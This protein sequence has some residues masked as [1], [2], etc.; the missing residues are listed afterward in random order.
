MK[1]VLACEGRLT[2]RILEAKF[3]FSHAYYKRFGSAMRAYELAGFLPPARTVKLID[4]QRKIKRLRNDLYIRLKQ[5][6]S[7]RVRFISLPGQQ[8]RQVV[9]IDG[10]LRIAIYLCRPT[11]ATSAGEPGW[12]VRVRP[13]EKELASL[14]CTMDQ[15]F[16]QL[17]NLY[18]FSS[19]ADTRKYRVIRE[20]QRWLSAGRK[21]GKLDDFCDIAKQVAAQPENSGLYIAVDDILISAST[22]M[23]ILGKKAIALGPVGS[24]IFNLLVLNAGQVVSRDRLRRAVPEKL[25]DPTNLNAHMHTLRVKLGVEAQNRI[26]RVPGIGYMYVSPDKNAGCCC[27]VRSQWSRQEGT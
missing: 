23:I 26:Q 12:I 25:L 3:T 10:R 21:L 7:D 22:W 8:F 15:T 27:G 20:N 4:T 14:I 6:F 11:N 17:L 18:V 13:A 24:A 2:K 16:S 5:L 19:L 1:R 9:E